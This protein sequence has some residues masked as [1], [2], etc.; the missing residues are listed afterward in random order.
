MA[1]V[2]END[3]IEERGPEA[4]GDAKGTDL[5]AYEPAAFAISSMITEFFHEARDFRRIKEETWIKNYLNFRGL[6]HKDVK[7]LATERSKAFVKITKTKTMAAYSQILDVLFSQGR[8]PFVVMP[9]ED[10]EGVDE[11]A[12]VENP[13]EKKEEPKPVDPI[14]YAGDGQD[15]SPGATM[16]SRLQDLMQIE[17][18]LTVAPGIDLN[19]SA[20]NLKPGD[21]KARKAE[22]KIRDQLTESKAEREIRRLLL[23]MCMMGT[24]ILKGPYVLKK[25]I[26]RWND[27]GDYEPYEKILPMVEQVSLWDLYPEAGT[28]K[29]SDMTRVV[30]RYRM[31]ARQLRELKMRPYFRGK[32]ID[33]L[34]TAGPNYVKEPWENSIEEST[35][36]S[37]ETHWQ[38]LEF[39]GIM[40]YSE[41]KE[42][43]EEGF[44]IDLPDSVKDKDFIHV[45]AWVSGPFLLRLTLNPFKPS[46]L[47]YRIVPYEEDIYNIFGVGV[48]E[49]MED[50]QMLMNGF[51]RMSIDN[52]VLS[53]SVLLEVDETYLVPGQSMDI[54]PGKI[55]R[56]SGGPPGQAIFSTKINNTSNENIQM[57][58]LFRRLSD[59]ATGIPSFSHGQTGVQGVG[60]T[61]SGISMLLGAASLNIKTV[62][63]NIDDFL[64]Q[65][66]IESFYAFN[67][68]FLRDESI[69]GDLE[70]K[71]QGTDSL[72]QKEIKTQRHLQ[73]LQIVGGNPEFLMR[74]DT[75]YILKQIAEGLDLDPD[76]VIR[77]PSLVQ[78][79]Q[80]AAQAALAAQQGAG[81]AGGLGMGPT[82]ALG[83]PGGGAAMGGQAPAVPGTEQFAGNINPQMDPSQQ[84][85]V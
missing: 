73:F 65:P 50:C 84:L 82:G 47:P 76:L 45:N 74:V 30:Q 51:T 67:M 42:L 69:K 40:S 8:L 54:Y 25:E 38:V 10:P 4:L 58:E 83:N 56:R 53:G 35:V 41:L 17:I 29:Y 68:N 15:L 37:E 21:I 63:K 60:R 26:P 57:F 52:A 14:G 6:Y 70:V 44:D 59:D 18:D 32:V 77:D 9:T 11:Y 72:L 34:I 62:I 78:M 7:F 22:K 79:I 48:P 55:F 31:D 5:G 43:E 64:I 49:N 23:E 3:Y 80:A 39:W 75:T 16:N 13:A 2:P 71:A 20:V 33:N 27:A 46:E 24:G 61:S 28:V 1:Q 81:P 19:Q 66:L 36:D 85:M 12:H